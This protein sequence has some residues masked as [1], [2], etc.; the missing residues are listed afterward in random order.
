MRGRVSAVNFLFIGTSNQLGEFESGLTAAWLG[1][2][3]AIVLGGIGSLLIAALWYQLFPE[4][5]RHSGQAA[6]QE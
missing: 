5:R 2:E 3:R 6:T 1:A 4:M